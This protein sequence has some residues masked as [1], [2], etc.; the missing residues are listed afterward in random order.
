[1]IRRPLTEG[2]SAMARQVFGDSLVL[3]RIRLIASPWPFDR[4]FVPGRWLGRDWIVWPCATLVDDI[5][6]APLGF[7]A[8]LIHELVHVWQA[9]R[10]V[11]LL[12]GK[13]R[14]GD[15]RASYA[16]PLGA[17][18]D[19][20]GLNIEQQAMVVEHRFRLQRGGRA[21]ADRAFYDRVCPF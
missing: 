9:Q 20:R 4:A 7:Q 1:M 11:N 6:T 16:Y 8:V 17:D 21:P 14:A 2:E 18:C 12:A 5:A 10:G 19:W 13:L 3:D 15:S